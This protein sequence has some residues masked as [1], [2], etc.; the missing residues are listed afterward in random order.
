MADNKP[1]TQIPQAAVAEPKKVVA[2]L[3]A[4]R[5]QSQEFAR[6]VWIIHPEVGTRP[7]D[8]LA[9]DYWSNITQQL[10]Q[11]DRIEAWSEDLKWYA[12]YLVLDVGRNWAKVHLC[13]ASVEEL[14]AFEP[15]SAGSILPGH[16]IEYAGLVAKWRVIRD[17]DKATVKDKCATN[18]EAIA[19]LTEYAKGLAR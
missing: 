4:S 19:W 8:L 12:E 1:Q 13:D 10:R 14:H 11:K 6:N 18:G 16:T 3:H 7:E 2:A 5:I 9:P 15:Q 17:K